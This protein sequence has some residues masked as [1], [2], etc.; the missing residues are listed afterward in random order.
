MKRIIVIG[1]PVSGKSTFSK[2]LHSITKIPLYHL[3]MMNWN[4]DRTTVP[5]EI[6]IK[7]L[8]Y[9]IQNE[10]WI[11]DGNYGSTIE[12][13]LQACDTVFFLDYTVDV[14]LRGIESRRGKKRNDMPWVEPTD[15]EDEEFIQFIENYNVASRPKVIN[16]LNKYSS[17]NTFIFTQRQQADEFLHA[18]SLTD[19]AK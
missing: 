13:R 16:L 4:A 10:L 12:L 1:C 9:T 19:L 3:D 11:I 18:L 15:E 17:K 8:Q 5:K 2:A 14:C 7:R 6:F